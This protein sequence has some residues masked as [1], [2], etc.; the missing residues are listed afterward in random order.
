VAEGGRLCGGILG[1]L[2]LIE[3]HRGALEYDWRTR[4]PGV[5]DGLSSVPE[6]MGWGEALRLVR[7]LRADPGSMLAAAIEGWDYPFPR[8]EAMQADLYDLQFA[9]TGAKNRK[10]YPRPYKPDDGSKKRRGNAAGRT[11]AE[12][13]EI[14][15]AHGHQLPV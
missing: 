14:L 9:K 2:D 7:I 12:V 10:P 1:L 4:C 11:R 6:R 15:N 13:V 8:G 3:E 5:P